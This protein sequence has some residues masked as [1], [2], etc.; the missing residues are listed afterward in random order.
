MGT[1]KWKLVGDLKPE[2]D[3]DFR[4]ETLGPGTIKWKFVR[5]AKVES[6]KSFGAGTEKS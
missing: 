6:E 2:V 4:P 3:E 5:E 1:I